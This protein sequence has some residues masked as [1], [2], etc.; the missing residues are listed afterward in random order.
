MLN[1]FF[2][3]IQLNSK[4][5]CAFFC[6]LASRSDCWASFV[7]KKVVFAHGAGAG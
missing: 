2:H 1:Y 5:F 7:V 6:N 3:S 4:D